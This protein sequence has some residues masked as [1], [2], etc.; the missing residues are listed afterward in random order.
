MSHQRQIPTFVLIGDRYL[1]T[2]FDKSHIQYLEAELQKRRITGVK[3][4]LYEY[5]AASSLWWNVFWW[6]WEYFN[7]RDVMIG[8]MYN[9]F[10]VSPILLYAFF[11]KSM[12]ALI[13]VLS[14]HFYTLKIGLRLRSGTIEN[15]EN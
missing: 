12:I 7:E 8:W 5:M 6:E 13:I 2:C 10:F 3:R 9:L 15:E 4:L 11:G 14:L 1:D